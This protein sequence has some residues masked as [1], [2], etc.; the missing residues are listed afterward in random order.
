MILGRPTN[1]WLGLVT[2]TVALAQGLIVI[3]VPEANPTQI[4]TAG[5]LVVAALGAGIALIAGQPPVLNP[6][7][8]YTVKTASGQDDVSKVANTNVTPIAPNTGVIDAK[9]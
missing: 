7:D 4:A 6:G 3:F 8:P 5:A 1:L 9:P 2:T